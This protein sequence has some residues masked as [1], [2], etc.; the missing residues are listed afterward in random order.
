[1]ALLYKA[2]P[3][4]RLFGHCRSSSGVKLS[5]VQNEMQ[6]FGS[7]FKTLASVV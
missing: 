2:V 6:Y 1:M 4:V 5:N 7:V 3:L